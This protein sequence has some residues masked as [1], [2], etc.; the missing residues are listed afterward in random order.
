M[1][2]KKI[3]EL[4]SELVKASK[5]I[6]ILKTLEWP[7]AAEQIF[8]AGWRRGNPLLPGVRFERLDLSDTIKTLDSITN[9]CNQDEPVERFLAD[10]AQSYS[11]AGQ[12]LMHVGTPD[13]T[14]YSTKIY[15][16]PDMVYKLQGL[17]AV[18]GA[19]FFLK[20]TDNLL[21]NTRFPPTVTD[22][23]AQDFARWLK[24]E[25]DE[26]FEHDSV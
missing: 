24:S 11:D 8:L 15:G 23:S 16:R 26:F 13:F 21:G 9:R 4:D 14:R 1:D 6:R 10:T 12:M 17:S 25:V 2:I 19:N 5:K 22:I 7:M 3:E 18:D 20:I